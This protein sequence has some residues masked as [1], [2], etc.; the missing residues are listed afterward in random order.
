MASRI[1]RG[2][3]SAFPAS[4][5]PMLATLTDK[6]SDQQGWIYEVKWDGYR[7]LALRNKKQTKL[8]SRNNKSFD[9][10]F[11]PVFEAVK[12][13]KVNA[14]IDGEICVLDSKG[15]AHF[16]SL[17]NW[18]TEADGELIYYVFD[19][20]WLEGRDLTGIPL[21]QRRQLLREILPDSSVIRMSED[22]PGTA[23]E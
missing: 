9:E 11:Y 15:V 7:A 17:Q 5:K 21:V 6:P 22:L 13:W 4:I 19:L 23:T 12:D 16:S 8:I 14:V 3:V 10:K 1:N 20:L 18:R 2:K